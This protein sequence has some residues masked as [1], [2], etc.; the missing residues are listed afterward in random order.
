MDSTCPGSMEK[1]M[2]LSTS[3]LPKLL[4][5]SITSRIAMGPPPYTLKYDS[6]FSIRPNK[7]VMIPQAT[8]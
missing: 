6:F 5:R 2:P 4:C 7:S 3:V 1:E 8:K